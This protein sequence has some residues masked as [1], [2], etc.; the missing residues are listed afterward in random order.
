MRYGSQAVEARLRSATLHELMATVID[1]RYPNVTLSLQV[2]NTSS[3]RCWSSEAYNPC[4]VSSCTPPSSTLSAHGCLLSCLTKRPCYLSAGDVS[5]LMRKIDRKKESMNGRV[6]SLR[7]GYGAEK[8]CRAQPVT[9]AAAALLPCTYR[10]Q[11][12][13]SYSCNQGSRVVASFVRLYVMQQ[14]QLVQHTQNQT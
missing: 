9:V 13:R 11:Q 2:L 12:G 14:S 10:V 5:C 8:H 3:G 6:H 7:H 1:A 4:P